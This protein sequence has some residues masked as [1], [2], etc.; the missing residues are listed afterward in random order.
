[1]NEYEIRPAVL[2]DAE[3]LTV[4]GVESF[5]YPRPDGPPRPPD[6]DGRRTYVATWR[7]TPVAA[8]VD[9]RYDSWFWGSRFRT[10]GIAGVKVALEHRG[11]GLL[12]P[13]FERM[14]SDAVADGCAISTLYAT[15]PGIYRRFGY[16]TVG[17]YDELVL[18]TAELAA[19]RT[20]GGSVRRGGACDVPVLRELYARWAVTHNGP[21]TR[22]GAS[23]ARTDEEVAGEYPGMT[24]AT[25]DDGRPSG[26]ALWSRSGGY[27]Q[28]GTLEVHDLVAV[29]DQGMRSLLRALG[30]SATVA[31]TTVIS[32]SAPDLLQ[33][34]LPSHVWKVRQANPYGLA[35]LDV[36]A[37]LTGRAYPTW[38][39][40]DLAFGVSGLPVGSDGAYRVRVADG[41]AAVEPAKNAEIVYTATGLALRYAGV[42]SCAE[43]R[44]AGLLSGADHDDERW[45][46]AFSGRRV[47]IRDYF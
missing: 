11:Q 38:L 47:H 40:L 33:L 27:G 5:G 4:L 29:T 26:Y 22:D 20:T 32:T 23:F 6:A 21:L 44:Q 41:R 45:D 18:P 14:L 2:D 37:A 15:A 7:G 19:V 34:A 3:A 35:V 42:S 1:M 28:D 10:A 30:T 46:A 24:I 43:L 39:D 13:L 36:A 9:R 25:D 31:P 12:T 16:E 8:V 17:S